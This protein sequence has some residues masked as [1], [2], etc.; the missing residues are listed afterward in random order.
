MEVMLYVVSF[1]V[2]GGLGFMFGVWK[3]YND[4]IAEAEPKRDPN[5]RFTKKD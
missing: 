3:G 4:G 1:L 5:G 2:A